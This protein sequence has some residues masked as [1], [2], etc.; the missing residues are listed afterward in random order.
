MKLHFLVCGGISRHVSEERLGKNCALLSGVRIL[1]K[2]QLLFIIII[3]IITI[4]IITY[5]QLDAS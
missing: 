1:R 4:I 3:I 5:L 2:I